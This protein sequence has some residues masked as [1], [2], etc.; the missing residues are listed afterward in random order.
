MSIASFRDR[1]LDFRSCWIV[2]IHVVQG[3]P[4]LFQFSKRKAVKIFV[5]S[6]A[7]GIRAMWLIGGN[8]MPAD[9]YSSMLTLEMTKLLTTVFLCPSTGLEHSSLSGLV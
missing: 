5:V 7:P 9:C 2:F 6:V 1:L 8:A 4:G 3:C